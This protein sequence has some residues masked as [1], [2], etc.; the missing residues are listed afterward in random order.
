MLDF[1]LRNALPEI[2]MSSKNLDEAIERARQT[3]STINEHFDM[4]VKYAR[5]GVSVVEY[6]MGFSTLAFLA[7]SASVLSV[8]I[9]EPEW[10]GRLVDLAEGRLV[11]RKCDSR[12]AEVVPCDLLYIDTLHTY[13]QLSQELARHG[14]ACQ[15]YIIMHDTEAFGFPTSELL[16]QFCAGDEGMIAAVDDFLWGNKEWY[17]Y[18][19]FAHQFGMTV[20]R[21]KP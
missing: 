20:L 16:V 10:M 3:P 11:F 7:S 13:A 2:V 1:D 4:L 14:G 19:R 15:K 6:G 17:I 5:C 8:D 18:E 21:R 9:E 12:A